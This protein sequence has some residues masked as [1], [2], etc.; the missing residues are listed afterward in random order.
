MKQISHN[1]AKINRAIRKRTEW[2][3]VN[4]PLCIFCGHSIG[5]YADPVHLIRRSN[6]IP[7]FDRFQIQTMDLN[8]WLGH[9]DCHDIF[10]NKPEEALLLPQFD[11]VMALIHQMSP[12][13]YNELTINVY[14][15]A[16]M[17]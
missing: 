6:A 4:Y 1:Q 9:R 8:L 12:E 10:D 3:F 5:K 7:D 2:L 11:L 13:V 16:N 15:E 17:E 14:G